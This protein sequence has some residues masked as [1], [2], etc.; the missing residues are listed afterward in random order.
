[1]KN[2]ALLTHFLGPKVHKVPNGM[3]VN[4]HKYTQDLICQ[5]TTPVGT[6]LELNVKYRKD[7]G[8]PS[9]EPSVY[10]KLV[11][12]LIYLIITQLEISHAIKIVSQVM[13]QPM[14]LHLAAQA[15]Y[16]VSSWDIQVCDVDQF[17]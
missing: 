11:G 1:M 7:H 12:S 9:S 14:H 17:P 4:Q 10:R 13:Q 15:H 3:F 16:S 2:L 6:S 5:N 8:T